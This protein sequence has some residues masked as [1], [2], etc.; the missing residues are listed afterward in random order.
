V[1]DYILAIDQGTTS[2]RAIVFN[3]QGLPVGQYQQ[4]FQQHF[5]AD[6]W[7]EHDPEEIWQTVLAS[8]RGAIHQ[9]GI[10]ANGIAALGIS[11]QRETTVI[12]DKASGE[13]IYNAIVWQDRRTSETCQGLVEQGLTATIQDKTGLLIDPY[14]SASKI[15]WLLDNV[16]GARE[17]AEQ[18]ELAFGTIDT[19]LLWRLTGGNVHAT[20][21]TNAARTMLFNIHEQVWDQALLAIFDIPALLLPQVKDTSGEFGVVDSDLLGHSIPIT[22]L[23]GDQQAAAIG[24]ACFEVGMVKST[25]GTGCFVLANTGDKPLA[26]QHRLLTTV[27]YRLNG[28]VTY[29]IEGSIFVAGAAVQW[30]R[31]TVNL[32][33]HASDTERHATQVRDTGGVYLVPAFTGLGAPYWDP[34]ARGA[35]FG[36]TRDSGVGQIV[37]AALEAVCYQTKDLLDSM[38]KDGITPQQLRVDGGMVTNDWLMQFLADILQVNV[39]RPEVTETSALGA[40]YMAG[41]AVGVFNSLDS[42]AELWHEERHFSPEMELGHRDKLYQGWIEAIGRVRCTEV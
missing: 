7:V 13:P 29:G 30:L 3:D 10:Q 21:A 24:Q 25:Y 26:S 31:D 1:K 23:V 32:I 27:V 9:A 18:G 4:E 39:K 28:E 14:F 15:Q 20:D 11:N 6:G 17:R 33:S 22:S 37:R 8:C 16:S 40:A 35:I 2:T 38:A 42:I 41:L 19:F 36:L 12:W 34:E 5:P